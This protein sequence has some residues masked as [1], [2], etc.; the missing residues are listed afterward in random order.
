M[1]HELNY[2]K[3]PFAAAND[4]SYIYIS[5]DRGQMAYFR[6]FFWTHVAPTKFYDN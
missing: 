6:E 2:H 5:R 4:Y 1:C 3:I